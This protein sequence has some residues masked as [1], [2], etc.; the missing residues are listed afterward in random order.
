[1]DMNTEGGGASLRLE[2]E[3]LRHEND[4]LKIM[5]G[6]M[7]ENFDLKSK[8]Q[9]ST[10]TSDTVRESTGRNTTI[11]WQDTVD[12]DRFKHELHQSSKH[13]H[14]TS[15]PINLESYTKR[16]MCTDPREHEETASYSYVMSQKVKDPERLVGEIAFQL[17]RRILSYVFQGQTRLYGFTVLN[18]RDKIIQVSTHPLTG[19]VDEGYRLQLSQRHSELM[20]RLNHLGYSMTLH[21]PFTEFII[22][23]YGILRQRPDSYSTQELGYNSPDFLRRVVINAAP[24]KLLKD[25]L[26]LFSCLSFMARQ[27]GKPLFLW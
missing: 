5:L 1:M 21:P 12:E 10:L 24:S 11:Q 20:A 23:T 4:D 27:D 13:P 7:K 8:L 26:L 6:L 22:N 16:C 17:D 9:T 2:N 18:I 14:R 15:S 25:L 3:K 19:K